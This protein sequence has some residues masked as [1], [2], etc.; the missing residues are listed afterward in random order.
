MKKIFKSI[1]SILCIIIVSIS[2]S[3]VAYSQSKDYLKRAIS[4]MEIGLFEESLKQLNYALKDNPKN[5]QIHKLKALLYEALE[6][7]DKAIKSWDEC[8]N[9]A[10]DQNMIKEAEIHINYLN[11]I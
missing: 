10:K 1:K 5:A 9:Y 3:A 6:N 11:G 4:A 2:L 7:K 8:I